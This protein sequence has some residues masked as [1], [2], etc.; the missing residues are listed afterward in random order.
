[1]RKFAGLALLLM[2]GILGAG[3]AAA[4][5]ITVSM[6]ATPSPAQVGQDVTLDL[7]L[8]LAPTPGYV[9]ASFISGTVT[10]MG[11]SGPV[12]TF[13][14][15]AG[16]DSRSLTDLISFNTA[17]LTTLTAIVS[18]VIEES[19]WTTAVI[20][21]QPIFG[22]YRCGPFGMS[23]CS[24]IVGWSPIYGSVLQ[25][26]QYG[27]GAG[28]QTQIQ[29]LAPTQVAVPAPPGL[30]ILGFALP[31]LALCRRRRTRNASAQALP[32]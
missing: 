10:V 11:G 20:G 6:Q 13:N 18:A 12:S 2:G 27:L 15:G 3:P 22:Y 30:A 28:D 29:I 24:Y 32:A 14:I 25:S 16:G 17:G 21:Q 23:T 5:L 9:S 19:Y 4:A 8:S 1:M 26:V 31:V 7:T